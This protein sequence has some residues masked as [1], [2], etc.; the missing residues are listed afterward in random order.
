MVFNSN[1]QVSFTESGNRTVTRVRR[2]NFRNRREGSIDRYAEPDVSRCSPE[3]AHFLMRVSTRENRDL[4]LSEIGI[5]GFVHACIRFQP[6]FDYL[7]PRVDEL[8][9]LCS[10]AIICDLFWYLP[11]SSLIGS[12]VQ[13]FRPD[14]LHI[15]A[16]E[17][18]QMPAD[19]LQRISIHS[20]KSLHFNFRFQTVA[21]IE[22]PICVN[23]VEIVQKSSSQVQCVTRSI[24]GSVCDVRHLR[25]YNGELDCFQ[26]MHLWGFQLNILSLHDLDIP[27]H[28]ISAFG[29]WLTSQAPSLTSL[30]LSYRRSWS[31]YLHVA[32]L[33]STLCSLLPALRL[34][35]KL[36]L[37]AGG[38][39]VP[40][41]SIVDWPFLRTFKID[42][43]IHS[44]PI[45]WNSLCVILDSP[46][47]VWKDVQFFCACDPCPANLDSLIPRIRDI[48]FSS[49][50][51]VAFGDHV[52]S[53]RD[54]MD[55]P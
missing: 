24:L 46:V 49:V 41:G 9:S 20:Y 8:W 48:H 7:A 51:G 30:T 39:I 27:T 40:F 32:Q 23:M 21:F 33:I 5:M 11:S 38:D 29:R 45:L 19:L 47:G 6:V 26:L 54:T 4:L 16:L 3:A 18:L 12:F 14:S 15:G 34:L 31:S 43:E 55:C 17:F 37:T 36:E 1:F 10:L 35:R 2:S 53:V 28:L 44:D 52:H 25:L 50:A 22:T 42:V 13:R